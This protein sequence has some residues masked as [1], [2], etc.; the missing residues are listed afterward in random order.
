M[1][2]PYNRLTPSANMPSIAMMTVAPANKIAHGGVHRFDGVA[3][4]TVAAVGLAE[5][6]HHEQRVVDADAGPGS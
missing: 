2:A 1:A 6:C 3:D 5:A 4:I